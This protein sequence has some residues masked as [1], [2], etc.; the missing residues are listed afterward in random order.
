M[1]CAFCPPL[2]TRHWFNT[3]IARQGNYAYAVPSVGALVPGHVLLVP[4]RHVVSSRRLNGGSVKEFVQFA[5]AMVDRVAAIYE[6]PVTVF[7]HGSCESSASQSSACI[8][9]AHVHVL[10]GDFNL[11]ESTPGKAAQFGSICDFIQNGPQCEP[12]LMCSDGGGAIYSF[13]DVGISQFYRRVIA[14]QLSMSHAWDYGAFP[15]WKNVRAT[16]S[17]FGLSAL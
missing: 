15:F 4:F 2:V 13:A 14:E 11:A 6:S 8:S 9:H 5:N 17:D 10:P 7:E 1:K 12:Y 16:Y 3:P